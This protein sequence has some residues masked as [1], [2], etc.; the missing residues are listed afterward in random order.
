MDIVWHEATLSIPDHLRV[1]STCR[2]SHTDGLV[3][4]ELW[5]ARTMKA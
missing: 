2:E 4:R 1:V 5:E 3:Y